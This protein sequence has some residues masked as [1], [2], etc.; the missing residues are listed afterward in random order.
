[1]ISYDDLRNRVKTVIKEENGKKCVIDLGIT[2]DD[3]STISH[4]EMKSIEE[5][6]NIVFTCIGNIILIKI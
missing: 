6:Y 5:E 2:V 3:I 4:E 1:M